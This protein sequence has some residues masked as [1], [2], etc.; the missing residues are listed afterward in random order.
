MGIMTLKVVASSREEKLEY[1]NGFHPKISH[2]SLLAHISLSDY[3]V[4]EIYNLGNLLVRINNAKEPNA[5]SYKIPV[6][7]K[8]LLKMDLCNDRNLQPYTYLF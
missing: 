1:Q 7:I 4:V 2:I 8:V 5:I 3:I 6:Y